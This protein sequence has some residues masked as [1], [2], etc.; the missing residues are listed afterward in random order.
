MVRG[1]LDEALEQGLHHI[2]AFYMLL[3]FSGEDG[4]NHPAI[5]HVL[6]GG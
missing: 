3:A 2:A 1:V 4:D 6:L 5:E